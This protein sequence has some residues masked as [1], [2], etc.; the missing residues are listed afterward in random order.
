MLGS[1]SVDRIADNTFEITITAVTNRDSDALERLFSPQALSEVDDFESG[2]DYLLNLIPS[3]V[4]S[5]ERVSI[6]S[7]D[8]QTMAK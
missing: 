1:Q 2:A 5:Y 4:S 7:G 3:G 8:K 6:F